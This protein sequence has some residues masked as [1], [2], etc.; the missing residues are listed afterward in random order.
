[1]VISCT[2]SIHIESFENTHLESRPEMERIVPNGRLSNSSKSDFM[3][4]SCTKSIHIESCENIH[5]E[6]RPELERMN[7]CYIVS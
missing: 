2:K 6:S 1:M 5:R 4:I 3:V 7:S